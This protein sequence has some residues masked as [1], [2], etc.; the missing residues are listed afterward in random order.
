MIK[1]HDELKHHSI[2]NHDSIPPITVTVLLTQYCYF[3]IF[4]AHFYLH[5]HSI[6][7]HLLLTFFFIFFSAICQLILH[8]CVFELQTSLSPKKSKLTQLV[9]NSLLE[10]FIPGYI[11]QNTLAQGLAGCLGVKY[12]SHA[13]FESSGG[14]HGTKHCQQCI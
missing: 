2:H 6:H 12:L 8:L 3:S 7:V 1:P 5:K 13:Q 4:D 10:V 9:Q 14:S 11:L